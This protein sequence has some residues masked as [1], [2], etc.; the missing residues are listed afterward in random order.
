MPRRAPCDADGQDQQTRGDA[1][2]EDFFR[3]HCSTPPRQNVAFG[4]VEPRRCLV[5]R[6]GLTTC[7]V[8]LIVILARSWAAHGLMSTLCARSREYRRSLGTATPPILESV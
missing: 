1:G 6:G 2:S 5:T 3:D 8:S 4:P 7:L